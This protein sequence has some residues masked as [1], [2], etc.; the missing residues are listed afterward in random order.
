METQT[1]FSSFACDASIQTDDV[2]TPQAVIPV[3]TESKGVDPVQELIP[4]TVNNQ[5]QVYIFVILY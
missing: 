4:V 1:M 3:A 2:G 5:A